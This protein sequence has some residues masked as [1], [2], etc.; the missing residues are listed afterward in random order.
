MLETSIIHFA[1]ANCNG[2]LYISKI[3]DIYDDRIR[4]GTIT[5]K[6]CS[7]NYKV[8]NY[9]PRFVSNENYAKGFGF[10]WN[11][12]IKTQFDSYN[13]LNLSKDRFYNSTLWPSNLSG[14]IIL[15]VGA[16]A[17]RFTEI[18]SSTNATVVSLD[19]SEAVEANY[20]MNGSKKNI[21]IV[22]G[23][24]YQ[25]PFRKHYFDKI[26]CFGVLQHTPD[27]KKAFMSLPAFLKPGGELVVDI[28]KKTILS[29]L[30]S[31]KYYVRPFLCKKDPK[32][33]YKLVKN[34]VDLMWPLVLLI[35]KL[36]KFGMTI[37]SRLLVAEYSNYGFC[38]E[39]LK[40]MAYLDTF[41]MLSPEYDKPQT[42]KTIMRWFEEAGLEK[43]D[44][45]YG[46][47]GIVG[48]GKVPLKNF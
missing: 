17:G 3:Q 9:I 6:S 25:M 31:T 41:D 22:Q 4:N 24:I 39:M 20:S 18:V 45:T 21:I 13:G 42:K 44:I 12:H 19:Y 29:T 47:N 34:Y 10:Q 28:Y 37:N 11:K 30:L 15:E 32:Q 36:P 7:N 46:Y 35:A 5:C 27:V 26:F 1:C 43:F 23:D 48:R 2:D 8:S 14:E 16:G 38:R 33:L 40:E